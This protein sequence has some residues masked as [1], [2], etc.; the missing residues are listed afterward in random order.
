MPSLVSSYLKPWRRSAPRAGVASS[1]EWEELGRELSDREDAEEADAVVVG[2]DAPTPPKAQ[3][4]QLESEATLD[5]SDDGQP[6]ALLRLRI[7][8]A[9]A[10]FWV[11]RTRHSVAI[12][13]LGLPY[14]ALSRALARSSAA[15]RVETSQTRRSRVMRSL[16]S[17][18]CALRLADAL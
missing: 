12:V 8:P 17:S 14:T 3:P 5:A 7:R 11:R 15:G 10:A 9:S 18:V 2:A 6:F 1:E 4:K 13:A 16:R